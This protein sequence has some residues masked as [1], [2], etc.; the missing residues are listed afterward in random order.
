MLS[1]EEREAFAFNDNCVCIA[2]KQYGPHN[3]EKVTKPHGVASKI[4]ASLNRPPWVRKDV[5]E[6]HDIVR[7]DGQMRAL[8]IT[9]GK[10]PYNVVK[11]L[12]VVSDMSFRSR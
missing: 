3:S 1:K 12:R 4:Q 7:N 10:E 8:F 6:L 11:Q 9:R 5:V 2:R